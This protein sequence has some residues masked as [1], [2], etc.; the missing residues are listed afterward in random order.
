[1]IYILRKS[2]NMGNIIRDLTNLLG[3]LITGIKA[4]RKGHCL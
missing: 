3:L 2:Y 4:D 1:M